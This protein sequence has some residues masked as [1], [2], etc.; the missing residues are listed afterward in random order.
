MLALE[1]T[2]TVDITMCSGSK[3][4]E[5]ITTEVIQAILLRRVA[6]ALVEL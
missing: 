3:P 4:F 1:A 6:V 5:N 2:I